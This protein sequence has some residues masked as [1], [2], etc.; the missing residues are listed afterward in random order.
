MMESMATGEEHV[1]DNKHFPSKWEEVVEEED[2]SVNAD[3]LI[4]S[5]PR[6]KAVRDTPRER[7][8]PGCEPYYRQ[9]EAKDTMAWLPTFKELASAEDWREAVWTKQRVVE[10][11]P[12]M[13][14]TSRSTGHTR[15][16]PWHVPV[17]RMLSS[18]GKVLVPSCLHGIED[19]KEYLAFHHPFKDEWRKQD[20]GSEGLQPVK[21]AE[22]MLQCMPYSEDK[23]RHDT[24][25]FIVKEEGSYLVAKMGTIIDMDALGQPTERVVMEYAHR[26]VMWAMVKVNANHYVRTRAE[27]AEDDRMR[28]LAQ[29]N[30]T[31][32]NNKCLNPMH[33]QWASSVSNAFDKKLKAKKAKPR[34]HPDATNPTHIVPLDDW[35]RLT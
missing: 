7:H 34:Y 1:L 31:C 8:M 17:E 3:Y 29:V 23:A 14:S 28:M 10:P 12:G 25:K 18:I 11:N 9:V 30:H 20:E 4:N 22:T 21:R 6:R 19:G 2:K 16:E 24:A 13:A 27:Q 15:I 26:L 32:F 5:P 35:A 33:M